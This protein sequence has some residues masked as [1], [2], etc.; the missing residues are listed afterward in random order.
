M[1]IGGDVGGTKTLLEARA[2]AFTLLKQR[3]QNDEFADFDALLAEFLSTL[4]QRHRAPV[5]ATC[6]AVAGPIAAQAAR[7][8]NRPAWLLEAA[9]LSARH[10]LG[11]TMLVN[12]F[13]AAAA[14]LGGL[15]AAE[16]RLLQTG[17]GDAGGPVLALGP[18]TGLG[19]AMVEGEH[20]VASEGGH[21]GFAP[22]DA[23]STALWQLLGAP[24]RRVTTE[25]V[26]SGTGLAACYR[27]TTAMS[28][29]PIEPAEVVARA[30]GGEPAATDAVR[31]FAR[32]FGAV[33][34]DL[35][36]V[37][38]A[39]GGVYLAGGITPRLPPELFDAPFLAAFGAK[40]EHAALVAGMPVLAVMSEELGLRGAL[41]LAMQSGREE[42]T[43]V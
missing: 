30:T 15:D 27:L 7:L 43:H 35:A 3:Y 23:E 42:K 6:L 36:L 20:V 8:T 38:L 33:A 11:P 19:V 37:F 13:V 21:I 34:G 17:H 26:V 25:Q 40:A 18:G 41:H 12:D 1:K 5:T 4:R 9:G 29:L 28:T 31:L 14:G 32:C 2:G 16:T 10:G 39:R 22:F 24:G